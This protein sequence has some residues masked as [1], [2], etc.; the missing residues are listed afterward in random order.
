LFPTAWRAEIV[1]QIV[2][3]IV[4]FAWTSL[5]T[6]DTLVT[7]KVVA[8]RRPPAKTV[9]PKEVRLA[10]LTGRLRQGASQMFVTVMPASAICGIVALVSP[11]RRAAR[12]Q[13]PKFIPLRSHS[14]TALA[15][16]RHVVGQLVVALL[17]VALVAIFA[18]R[19]H[20]AAAQALRPTL[21]ATT[22]FTTFI[23]TATASNTSGDSTYINNAA[24]NGAPNAIVFVTAN[25]NPN[26]ACG[27]VYND[28]PVGVWYTGS[29]WAIFNEDRAAMPIGT[30]FNVWI[31]DAPECTGGPFGTAAAS[32][33][34]SN[35]FL[36]GPPF[37][38]NPNT[39]L[40]V[41]PNW[42]GVFDNDAVGV[43]YDASVGQWGIFNENPQ[44]NMPQGAVF[45]VWSC[46]P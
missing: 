32:S 7:G 20:V 34:I 22:T 12:L 27:C 33:P 5:L 18:Q 16:A 30:S 29:Q 14:L 39:L 25:W 8:H 46:V 4:S 38:T 9:R 19:P 41:T 43:W 15:C 35:Y 37:P 3:D 10:G 11:G 40:W 31:F 45:D 17:S 23:Q 44:H 42:S 36:L 28:H 13:S 24:T 2:T 6:Q 21:P 26:G 1:G